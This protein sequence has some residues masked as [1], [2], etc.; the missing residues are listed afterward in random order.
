VSAVKDRSGFIQPTPGR[1]VHRLTPAPSRD[2]EHWLQAEAELREESLP[3]QSGH[4]LTAEGSDVVRVSGGPG[5]EH[6]NGSRK[7]SLRRG[8]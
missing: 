8:K 3:N 1:I 2:Q 7:R 6:S 4:Q 5:K